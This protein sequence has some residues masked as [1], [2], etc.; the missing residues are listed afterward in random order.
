MIQKIVL[1]DSVDYAKILGVT[2]QLVTHY[3]RG[4]TAKKFEMNVLPGLRKVKKVKRKWEL[5]VDEN[6]ARTGKCGPK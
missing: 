1:V 5:I 6:I 2:P 4:I 3:L